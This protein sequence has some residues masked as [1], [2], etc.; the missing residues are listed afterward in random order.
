MTQQD[1]AAIPALEGWH[2]HPLEDGR[3]ELSLEIP[4]RVPDVSAPL[5]RGRVVDKDKANDVVRGRPRE[6]VYDAPEF[7]L[8]RPDLPP[9]KS[10]SKSG[11]FRMEDIPFL[12]SLLR[13][14]AFRK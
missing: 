14:Q 4:G 11:A 2:Y 3:V 13:G 9:K 6:S 7:E 5:S 8:E 1:R 12:G 10:N